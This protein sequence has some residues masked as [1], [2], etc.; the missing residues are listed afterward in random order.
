M[1]QSDLSPFYQ[2]LTFNLITIAL[3]MIAFIYGSSLLLP[4]FFAVLFANLLLP[5]VKFLGRQRFNRVFSILVPLVLAVVIGAT[6]IVLLS[7]QVARFFDD[8]PALREKSTQLLS[9][10]QS[11]INENIH[12]AINKQNQY[13]EE[14]KENIKD[15]APLI[16][17]VT[18]ASL[19][20]MISYCILVPI[21]TF[22][23]LYYRAIIK[24]FL[25][26]L[27]TNGSGNQV[28]EVLN[29]STSV[30]QAYMTGLMIETTIVFT[31]NVIGF[32]ILGIQYAVFLALLAALLNLIPY[33]GILVAN[34]IC[35]ITTLISSDNIGDVIWVGVILALVQ[36]FDNNFGMP[37]IVGTKVR[38]N[39]LV[40]ILG[41]LLGGML[42]G[43]PGMFLA[44]PGLA[45][46][47]VLFDNVP[48]LN[49]WSTLLGDEPSK[50]ASGN[51][52]L[53]R[54]REKSPAK[55]S[56]TIS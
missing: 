56:T 6:V 7:S 42:G 21:Y 22:L 8:L 19:F 1:K 23:L 39:A 52:R 46:L 2:R 31:L 10:F 25:I 49:A 43:I 54:S 4:F 50:H 37:V 3:I 45:F 47:K 30:A 14:T 17:G 11:W 24:K 33:V 20:S 48:E 29:E 34:V 16:V 55:Q 36:L 35:M 32:L 51:F 9:S 44:I 5:I 40:T 28:E 13:I 53:W 15:K 12:I 18:F 41:V 26:K 38:I 27:F